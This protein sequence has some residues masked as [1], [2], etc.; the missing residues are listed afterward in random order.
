MICEAFHLYLYGPNRGAMTTSFEDAAER[1]ERMPKLYFEPDGSFVWARDGGNE[2][3][4]GMLYDAAGVVQYCDMRGKC[5]RDTFRQLCQAV[6]GTDHL[7]NLQI[8]RLPESQWQD[9]QSFEHL[10]W[11]P[12]DR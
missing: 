5:Q 12:S 11:T 3:V 7:P 9:F 10:T 4:Y 6:S 8:M 2:Q 1:L